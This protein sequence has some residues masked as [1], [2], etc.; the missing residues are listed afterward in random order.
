MNALPQ[1]LKIL[2]RIQRTIVVL[3]FVVMTMS[4]VLDV[5]FRL[6]T[7]LGFIEAPRI[8]VFAMMFASFLGMALA[9]AEGEHLRPQ[10]ADGLLPKT[11]EPVIIRLQE[12]IF[13]LF[14]FAGMYFAIEVV[15]E[16]RELAERTR[17]LK[18][19]LWPLQI[20][21]PV[22]FLL[23]GLHHLVYALRPDLRPNS[24]DPHAGGQ[25]PSL[26]EKGD[27]S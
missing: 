19:M 18:I 3:I 12:A 13:A 10:F 27:A 24:K 4:I 25:Q 2:G 22:A 14:L 6:V 5:G 23:T 8:A 20:V 9:S 17:T 1:L 16:S 11:W 7:G 26:A 15:I 21:L